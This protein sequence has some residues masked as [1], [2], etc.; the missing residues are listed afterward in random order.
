V[1]FSGGGG[2]WL[3]FHKGGYAY[4]VYTGIGKWGPHGEPR[5]KDG[6][7]VEHAGKLVTDLKCTGKPTSLLG[8]D[9]FEKT[10]ITSNGEEFEFPE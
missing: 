1:A 6:V 2:A 5:T 8:P 3:R 10:G 4:V 9:W 7:A